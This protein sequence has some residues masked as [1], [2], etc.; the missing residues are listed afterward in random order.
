MAQS[1][2][3]WSDFLD[4]DRLSRSISIS[5]DVHAEVVDVESMPFLDLVGFDSPAGMPEVPSI[6][7]AVRRGVDSTPTEIDAP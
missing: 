1:T 3:C 7:A 6:A 4:G 5:N 2:S